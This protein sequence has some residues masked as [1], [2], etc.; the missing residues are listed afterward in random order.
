MVEPVITW[1]GLALLLVLCLPFATV[2]KLVLEVYGWVLRLALLALLGGAAYLWF[3]PKELPVE[4]TDTLSNFPR[5]RAILPEPETPNFGICAAALIVAVLLPLLIVLDVS[6]RLAGRR[7]RRL[8]DLA[9]G[10]TA[11]T[12]SPVAA[13]QVVPK[14]VP[15]RVDRRAAADTMAQASARK[16]SHPTDRL[17]P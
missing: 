10:R 4:V 7:L 17:E 5:L 2:Q 3:R 12:P 6:R 1:V 13:S 11:E 16:L 8:R 15:R 9:A 14:P